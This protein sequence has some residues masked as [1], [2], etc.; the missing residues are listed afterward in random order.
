MAMT[1]IDETTLIRERMRKLRGR[2]DDRASQLATSTEELLDWKTYAR[3]HPVAL[4]VAGLL[5]GFVIAPGLKLREKKTSSPATIQRD[6]VGLQ[7]SVTD[8]AA[9]KPHGFISGVL[10]S[11]ISP[12]VKQLLWSYVK[13]GAVVH[14]D[15]LLRSVN[16]HTAENARPPQQQTGEV[17]S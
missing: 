11:T 6:P 16:A 15:S 13:G 2:L 12:M 5:T 3:R 9:V 17:R 14:I 10:H 1:S 4:V 8:V 7:N